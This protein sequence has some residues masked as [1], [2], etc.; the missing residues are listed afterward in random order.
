MASLLQL[1]ND[2]EWSSICIID[3]P[4]NPKLTG[5]LIHN[6]VVDLNLKNVVQALRY[7]TCVT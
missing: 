4:T 5:D 1:L 2:N 7:D 6:I 3:L